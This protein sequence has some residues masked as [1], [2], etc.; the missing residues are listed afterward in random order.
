M[1]EKMPLVVSCT[2]AD[3]SYNKNMTCNA[4]AVTI[5]ERTEAICDTYYHT[6]HKVAFPETISFI[7]AC[8]MEACT[9]NRNLECTAYA[10]VSLVGRKGQVFCNTYNAG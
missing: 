5:G 7:G 8:K 9:F 3:C 4:M 10:G 6:D 1:T 2:G